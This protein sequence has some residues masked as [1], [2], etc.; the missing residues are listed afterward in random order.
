MATPT[1]PAERSQRQLRVGEELKHVMC[2]TLRKGRFNDVILM[3]HAN[4]V[5][6]TEVQV[7]PDLKHATAYIVTLGGQHMDTI[8]PALNESAAI[9]QK[10]IA[11]NLRLKFT[12]RVHFRPD[13]SFDTASR[14]NTILNQI[15][16]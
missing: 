11:R 3:D 13:H 5:T 15:D 16:Q 10:D 4:S 12:P 14:I 9:F 8:L 6:I 7:S 2:D 1:G